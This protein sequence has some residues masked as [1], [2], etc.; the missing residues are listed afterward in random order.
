M[1]GVLNLSESRAHIDR[2]K[3]QYDELVRVFTEWGQ[4]G[5]VEMQTVRD[6]QFACYRWNVTVRSGIRLTGGASRPLLA[7]I[8]RG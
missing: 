3:Q 2:A 8:D 1:A 6:P 4:S 5:G 7:S